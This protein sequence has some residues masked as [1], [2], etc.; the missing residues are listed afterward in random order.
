MPRWACEVG[1]RHRECLLRDEPRSVTRRRGPSD[2]NAPRGVLS[3]GRT[4][5]GD[6]P[7]LR[8]G[9]ERATGR[10]CSGRNHVRWRVAAR[11][12][13]VPLMDRALTS[14]DRLMDAH[15]ETYRDDATGVGFGQPLE[16]AR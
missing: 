10:V 11:V 15:D 16:L 4:T 1:A 3:P 2:R 6:A 7:A 13:K 8:A 5:L 9:S 12:R 14:A